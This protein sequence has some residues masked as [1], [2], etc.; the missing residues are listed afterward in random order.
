MFNDYA[1][2]ADTY[3]TSDSSFYFMK[4]THHLNV[5]LFITNVVNLS[6]VGVKLILSSLMDAALF[7]QGHLK[8]LGHLK[9][10]FSMRQT[11]H[12]RILLSTLKTVKLSCC[13]IPLSQNITKKIISTLNQ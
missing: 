2:D 12:W 10:Y 11:K 13:P 6:F 5:I 8:Y 4:G 9:I 1:N 7:G 3:F